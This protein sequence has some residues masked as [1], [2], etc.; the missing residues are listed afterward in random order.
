MNIKEIDLMR[1][2]KKVICGDLTDDTVSLVNR[3][4]FGIRIE[5]PLRCDVIMVLGNPSCLED[6]LPTALNLWAEYDNPSMLLSGGVEINGTQLTEAENMQ[7]VCIEFGIHSENI[8]IENESTTTKENV[9]FCAELVKKIPVE[10][11]VIIV[12][13]SATHIRRVMMN[14]HKHASLYKPDS[15]VFPYFSVHA[16]CNPNTWHLNN[17]SRK[18][19]ATE[20]GFIHEYIFELGYTPFCI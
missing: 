3:I 7:N 4:M 5:K 16:S 17:S 14:F 6:R 12:V 20:L 15:M 18:I 13:S 2:R 9:V 19:I 11:P 8:I 10:K 1:L